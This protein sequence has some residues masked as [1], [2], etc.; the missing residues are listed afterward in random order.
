MRPPNPGDARPRRF[1]TTA[2]LAPEAGG[3][4]VKLDGRTAR[5]PAG[6]P[7]TA[8]TEALARL[9]AEEW[10]TQGETVDLQ[11]MPAQRLAATV[12]D[13]TADAAP[14]LAAEVA[15]YAGS[16]VLC[17][18]AD[19]PPSLVEEE[20][21]RWDPLLA[22]ARADLGVDL[23]PIAGIMHRP[24]PPASLARVEALAGALEPF[25]LAATAFAAP[26][27]GSAVLALAVQRGR[28]QA[29]AAFDLS[30]LDEAFQEARWGV[31]AEAA[32][33][34][35]RLREEARFLQR[36]FAALR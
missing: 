20:A 14:A 18:R 9:V 23:H 16:D 28:L 19:A 5:T 29:E 25:A 17:Y 2:D 26:L 10:A 32:A 3:W 13:R 1:Y 33:R 34:T 12:I 30:R 21:A 4:A 27:F 6:A 31:D 35:E 11:A 8:P 24:Q 22:W 7:V 36:W 15:R